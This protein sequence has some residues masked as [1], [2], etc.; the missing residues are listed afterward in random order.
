MGLAPPG[1]HPLGHNNPLPGVISHP[2]VSGLPWRELGIGRCLTAL[3]PPQ[4]GACD[5]HR[6]PLKHLKGPL[7]HPVGLTLPPCTILFGR[8]DSRLLHYARLRL[9]SGRIDRSFSRDE[10]PEG[11]QPAFAE[12]SVVPLCFM[13]KQPALFPSSC[14]RSSIGFPCGALSPLGELRAYH[15]PAVYL[16]G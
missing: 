5:F 1:S 9:R 3:S 12:D 4:N 13:T 10:T 16:H 6:T 11:S 8:F 2:Q 14:T 7:Q 15:V